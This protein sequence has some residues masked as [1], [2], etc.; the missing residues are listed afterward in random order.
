MEDNL[1]PKSYGAWA[2]NPKGQE[3]D[4]TR[5][6][7]KVWSK[8]SWSRE[9]QC[10]RKR[11]Y[12]P[13]GAYCRQ[14][15]PKVAAERRKQVDERYQEKRRARMMEVHGKTFYDALVEIAAGNNDARGLAREVIDKFKY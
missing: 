2:G 7:A 6:C 3:P 14:H 10:N 5:C 15:D 4:L 9:G 8:D 1:Y 11:G 12:G 13:D